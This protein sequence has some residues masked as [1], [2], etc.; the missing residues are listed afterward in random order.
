MSETYKVIEEEA[1]PKTSYGHLERKIRMFLTKY[2][3][4][5]SESDTHS[6]TAFTKRKIGNG[7]LDVKSELH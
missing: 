3:M 5:H 7:F 4:I 6:H 2:G 1:A